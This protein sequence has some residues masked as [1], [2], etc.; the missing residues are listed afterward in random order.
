MIINTWLPAC[1]WCL[2]GIARNLPRR[3]AY[4]RGRP[5]GSTRPAPRRRSRWPSWRR[6]RRCGRDR[7][8][9]GKP[10]RRGRPPQARGLRRGRR[11]ATAGR[12]PS[13]LQQQRRL[14]VREDG[15][16]LSGGESHPEGPAPD[17][18]IFRNNLKYVILPRDPHVFLL[19]S[20]LFAPSLC[21]VSS[22]IVC[23]CWDESAMGDGE[24]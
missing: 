4:R 24:E 15:H 5:I 10:R 22:S 12:R 3:G 23:V 17:R 1:T 14:G 18:R 16:E 6:G 2:L 11:W 21:Q 9:V 13:G 20:P 8:R 19:R 7:G